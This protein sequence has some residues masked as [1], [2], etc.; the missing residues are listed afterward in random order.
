MLAAY[1]YVF[2]TILSLLAFISFVSADPHCNMTYGQPTYTD[3]LDLVNLLRKYDNNAE[4][5]RELF[6]ALR[7]EEPP[8]WIPQYAQIFRT[9]LPIFLKQG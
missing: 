3:C 8:P 9:R 7:G 2:S 6:F 5:A 1:F 4:N